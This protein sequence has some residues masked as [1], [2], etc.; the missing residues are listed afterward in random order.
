M[1]IQQALFDKYGPLLTYA[2]LAI[3]LDRSEAGLKTT[4]SKSTGHAA[5]VLSVAKVR[6]GNRAYFRTDQVADLLERPQVAGPSVQ[7]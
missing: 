1:D 3:I 4:L 2:Q 6:I 5:T 7:A